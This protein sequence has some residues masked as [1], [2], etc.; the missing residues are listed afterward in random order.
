MRRVHRLCE[1]CK[2]EFP[3]G[4]PRISH[5]RFCDRAC[6]FAE[7]RKRQAQ[8]LA[9]RFWANANARSD[10]ESACWAWRL[11][12]NSQGYG[13]F[14]IGGRHSLAHR[15]AWRLIRGDIPAGAFVCHHCD[16]PLCVRPDHLF[17][18]N[19]ADNMRDMKLKGRQGL[20]MSI[21]KPESIRRGSRHPFAKLNE[22]AARHIREARERGV[23]LAALSK[24]FGVAQSVISRVAHKA[25]WRH[26]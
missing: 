24:Q 12:T 20:H 7:K 10:D 18:G 8:T 19:H 9:A 17:L 22:T 5:R 11:S 4:A 1:W 6:Y 16:N 21:T 13:R 23:P 26:A 3:P 25:I 2:R 14:S 15:I